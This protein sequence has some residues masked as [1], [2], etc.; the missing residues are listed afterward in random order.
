MDL[1]SL[2][3]IIIGLVL[4]PILATFVYLAVNNSTLAQVPGITIILPLI[5]LA[6]GFGMVYQGIKGAMK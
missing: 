5:V 2:F 3:E 1:K 6:I 4:L